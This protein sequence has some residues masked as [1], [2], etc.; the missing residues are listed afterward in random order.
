MASS[1]ELLM[2]QT[3]R[4]PTVV[5]RPWSHSNA[6]APAARKAVVKGPRYTSA[7]ITL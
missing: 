3:T 2:A 5:D 6:K 7:S 1:A 4:P